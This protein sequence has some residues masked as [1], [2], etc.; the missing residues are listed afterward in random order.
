MIKSQNDRGLFYSES[1]VYS[2]S[3][4]LIVILLHILYRFALNHFIDI[5][6]QNM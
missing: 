4:F 3:M 6:L 5:M 2:I 1:L